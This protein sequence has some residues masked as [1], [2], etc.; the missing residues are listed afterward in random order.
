MFYLSYDMAISMSFLK[1]DGTCFHFY[2]ET[3]L[4]NGTNSIVLRRG[5]HA[6]K[7][8]KVRDTTTMS[9]ENREDVEY[10]NEVNREMLESE[11]AVYLR[12]GRCDGIA[13]CINISKDGILLALYERGDLESYIEGEVE[14]DRSR[15]AGWML[16]IIK[17]IL[18][19]HN[20]KILV[21][22]MAL[23]N[24]LIADDLSLK[25]IDFGQCP[26]LPL[27]T[28]IN[29]VSDHGLT[30]QADIFHLGC[31]IYSIVTWKRYECNL[32]M[33]GWTRPLLSNLPEVDQLFWG[34]IIQK[35]WSAEYTS[36]EQLYCDTREALERIIHEIR[37]CRDGDLDQYE[38]GI[39]ATGSGLLVAE[40]GI[41][42]CGGQS[43]PAGAC[44]YESRENQL[45]SELQPHSTLRIWFPKSTS[46]ILFNSLSKVLFIFRLL[47]LYAIIRSPRYHYFLISNTPIITIYIALLYF[48]YIL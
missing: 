2:S 20:A 46:L 3:F 42:P 34:D 47:Y 15:K 13:E 22:D 1:P 14:V 33:R 19:F 25:M 37:C 9:E 8:P 28:D 43:I 45:D 24:I 29:A 38:S 7:I 31:I 10:V 44:F 6:F 16:S 27:D 21:D 39:R 12:V 23:R 40:G 5:S 41:F 35:C 26:L 4:G 11:K 18:L 17:T 36:M 30:A 48:S 32:F